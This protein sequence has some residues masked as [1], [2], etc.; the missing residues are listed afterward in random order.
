MTTYLSKLPCWLC[1]LDDMF[2]EVYAV[3]CWVRFDLE[4]R[5]FGGVAEVEDGGEDRGERGKK[6]ESDVIQGSKYKKALDRQP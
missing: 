5:V 6:I 1:A 2:V 3:V 4:E